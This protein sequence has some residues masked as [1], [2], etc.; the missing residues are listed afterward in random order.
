MDLA[1]LLVPPLKRSIL[2]THRDMDHL[3]RLASAFLSAD[4]LFGLSLFPYLLFLFHARRSRR[5]PVLAWWGF[6]ATLVFVVVTVVAGAIAEWRYHQQLADVDW[7]H[8]GAEAFLTAAN[9]LVALGFAGA[10]NGASR[11]QSR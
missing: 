8:G 3:L 9:L 10:G 2:S 6:L 11:Q 1:S 4:T 7:L 5:F